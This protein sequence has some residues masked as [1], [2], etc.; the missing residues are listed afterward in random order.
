MYEEFAKKVRGNALSRMKAQEEVIRSKY[1]MVLDLP[2]FAPCFE[3][4]MVVYE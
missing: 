4:L 2:K 3:K 1:Q